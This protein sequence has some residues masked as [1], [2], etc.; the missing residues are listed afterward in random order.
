MFVH[1]S[2]DGFGSLGEMEAALKLIPGR[3]RLVPVAGAGHDL[4]TKSSQVADG[5]LSAFF[6][7]FDPSRLQDARP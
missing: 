3:T 7:F 4:H 5:V 6:H 2:R 1:G